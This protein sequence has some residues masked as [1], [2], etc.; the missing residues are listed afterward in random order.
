MGLSSRLRDTSG[1]FYYGGDVEV[2]DPSQKEK[3]IGAA[4]S[5]LGLIEETGAGLMLPKSLAP[6]KLEM[7]LNADAM[8]VAQDF[9]DNLELNLREAVRDR[10]KNNH[11][12]LPITDA[13]ILGVHNAKQ[14]DA[15]YLRNI[16]NRSGLNLGHL[17]RRMAQTGTAPCFNRRSWTH[18]LRK[19]PRRRTCRAMIIAHD[20]RR[21]L[22]E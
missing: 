4:K 20:T 7:F 6:R 9:A 10:Q 19:W 22:A 15:Y 5:V 21:D 12:D 1:S 8:K 11:M 18:W 16:L 14:G 17:V 3:F 13:E 2:L